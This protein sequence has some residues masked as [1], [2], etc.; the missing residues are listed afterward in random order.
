VTF[1]ELEDL[2]ATTW[3]TTFDVMAKEGLV[4]SRGLYPIWFYFFIGLLLVAAFVA[5]IAARAWESVPIAIVPLAVLAVAAGAA[6]V[7]AI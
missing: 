7:R 6:A 1:S 2:R 3:R 4:M 5:P